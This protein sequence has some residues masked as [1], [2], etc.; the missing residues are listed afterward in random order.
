MVERR[1]TSAADRMSQLTG[2][3]PESSVPLT[4]PQSAKNYGNPATFWNTINNLKATQ[5]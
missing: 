2:F 4:R 1:R 3:A 5:Q